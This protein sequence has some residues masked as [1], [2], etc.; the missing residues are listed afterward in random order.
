MQSYSVVTITVITIMVLYYIITHYRV[1][2]SYFTTRTLTIITLTR[3]LR[4]NM[5]GPVEIVL[6]DFDYMFIISLSDGKYVNLPGAL[7]I[8]AQK[9]NLF[10]SANF[11]QYSY[12]RDSQVAKTAYI[13]HTI[14]FVWYT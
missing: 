9:S 12:Y 3:L 13:K 6:T 8:A 7:N 4:T 1:Q 2:N 5:D 11:V 10:F 14:Y